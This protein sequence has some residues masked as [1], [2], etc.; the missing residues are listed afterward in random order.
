MGDLLLAL[1]I[2]VIVVVPFAVLLARQG[3][4]GWPHR[5]RAAEDGPIGPTDEPYPPGSRPAGPGAER[6]TDE[7]PAEESEWHEDRNF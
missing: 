4:P 6:M 2:T 7:P 1:L 3:F 5:D